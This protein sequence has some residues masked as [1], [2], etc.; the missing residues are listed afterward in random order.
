M[1]LGGSCDHQYG[2]DEGSN[3]H[4]GNQQCHKAR[5]LTPYHPRWLDRVG[6]VRPVTLIQRVLSP[7]GNNNTGSSGHVLLLPSNKV[8]QAIKTEWSV[9][10]LP[11][12]EILTPNGFCTTNRNGTQVG[13]AS[14]I[15]KFSRWCV[16]EMDV[17]RVPPWICHVRFHVLF[18]VLWNS[19]ISIVVSLSLSNDCHLWM[20]YTSLRLLETLH[21]DMTHTWMNDPKRPQLVSSD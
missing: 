17:A 21:R 10:M 7:P 19:C 2:H 15:G 16:M 1:C 20:T 4:Q 5:T 14:W 9:W 11:V 18:Y 6:G 3:G 12:F 8:H 13:N